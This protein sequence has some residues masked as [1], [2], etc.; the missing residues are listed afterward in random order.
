MWE[1]R[2]QHKEKTAAQLGDLATGIREI[3]GNSDD[4]DDLS[5]LSGVRVRIQGK[6]TVEA[7]KEIG[8]VLKTIKGI[9]PGV[10]GIFMRRVQG[11]WGEVFP[12]ADERGLKAARSFGLV[13]EGDGADE[14]AR[15][16]GGDGEEGRRKYVRVLDTLVGLELE[17]KVEEAVGRVGK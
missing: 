2:T 17:K 16:V 1:A 3:C 13:G 6:G 9:G 8:D 4:E 14:L 5:E 15:A 11:D 10:V 12:F 7:Q